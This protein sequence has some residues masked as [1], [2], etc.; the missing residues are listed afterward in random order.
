MKGIAAG[1]AEGGVEGGL[2]A[3]EDRTGEH[4]IGGQAL[5][6]WRKGAVVSDVGGVG[7]ARGG[8]KVAERQR[9]ARCRARGHPRDCDRA[10]EQGAQGRIDLRPGR[11]RD[12]VASQ[13]ERDR[14]RCFDDAAIGGGDVGVD[15]V[16]HVEVETIVAADVQQVQLS[17]PL[18]VSPLGGPATHQLGG[19]GV[20]AT[21]EDDVHHSLI[22]GVAIL[23]RHLLGEDV[24]PQDRLGW[25][26]HDLVEARDPAPVQQHHR[27]FPTAP[28]VATCLR[29]KLGEQ[30][31]DGAYAEGL[32]IGGG[33]LDLGNDIADHRAKLVGVILVSNDIHARD[34]GV[35]GMLGVA[36]IL[37][38]ARARRRG[39]PGRLL[40]S[41]YRRG[42]VGRRGGGRRGLR[43]D[44]N[45]LRH[46][47]GPAG[48]GYQD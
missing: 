39:F 18:S 20:E 30:I 1:G 14:R 46:E 15:I 27:A 45:R 19:G 10:S 31:G 5:G 29:R 33:V 24:D 48:A 26:V 8:N 41:F 3:I 23:Q 40:G 42:R 7:D 11:R 21:P 4:G 25:N 22:G 12:D 32:D 34:T 38:V 44:A 28:A 47:R 6:R 2:D 16:L 36:R 35:A 37:L 9:P 17:L 43:G 13:V